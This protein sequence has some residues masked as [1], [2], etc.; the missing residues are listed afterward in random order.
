MPGSQGGQNRELD[1]LGLELQKVVSLPLGAS[2]Q[3]LL[4]LKEQPGL[5]TAKPSLQPLMNILYK[6]TGMFSL[7]EDASDIGVLLYHTNVVPNG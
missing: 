4:F 5:S 2:N 3:I 6:R 1:P 7:S